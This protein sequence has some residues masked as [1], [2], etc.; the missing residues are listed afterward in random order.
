MSRYV[1][2]CVCQLQATSAG[3][4][5]R[6]SPEMLTYVPDEEAVVHMPLFMIGNVSPYVCRLQATSAGAA[7][8]YDPE[9]MTYVPE[10]EAIPSLDAAMKEEAGAEEA[11]ATEERKVRIVA[12]TFRN[13]GNA[14]KRAT[15]AEAAA[16]AEERRLRCV[17]RIDKTKKNCR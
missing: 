13:G 14:M 11:A 15:G 7:P 12:R 17:A 10:E 3:A 9:M 5:P 8:G 6:Y 2:P 16:A 1:S 4:A